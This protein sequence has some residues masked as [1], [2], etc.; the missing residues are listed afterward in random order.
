MANQHIDPQPA[1]YK[2]Y[3]HDH[4]YDY[5]PGLIYLPVASDTP[6]LPARIRVH[7][8]YGLRKTYWQAVRGNAP[9]IIPGHRADRDTDYDTHAQLTADTERSD[10]AAVRPHDRAI[11]NSTKIYLPMPNGTSG[12]YTYMASGCI[13]SVQMGTEGPRVP[14][15]D[16]LP[17]GR[18]PYLLDLIDNR[19][20]EVLDG[21]VLNEDID[22]L[23]SEQVSTFLSNNNDIS[24][25]KVGWPV[26]IHAPFF[27]ST[28]IFEE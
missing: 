21:F 9:P 3:Q 5:D 4:E 26:T 25:R 15:V 10:D 16:P 8:G 1:N 13:T 14:G 18:R 20:E 7:G 27:T 2:R 22:T 11:H 6:E 12:G 19:S 23:P 24:D 17:T 28:Y